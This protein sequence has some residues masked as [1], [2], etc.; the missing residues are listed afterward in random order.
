L[1]TLSRT[2]TL[3]LTNTSHPCPITIS[4]PFTHPAHFTDFLAKWPQPF[5]PRPIIR[6][7]PHFAPTSQISPIHLDQTHSLGPSRLSPLGPQRIFNSSEAHTLQP[8]IVFSPLKIDPA[9]SLIPSSLGPAHPLPSESHTTFRPHFQI[10]PTYA[11]II[12]TPASFSLPPPP[13][14]AV[15]PP[16]PYSPWKSTRHSPRLSYFHPYAKPT[17]LTITPTTISNP[18]LSSSPIV[19][20]SSPPKRKWIEID[21]IPLAVLKKHRGQHLF[22]RLMSNLDWLPFLLPH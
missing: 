8:S 19:L 9:H 12:L 6:P 5:P 2:P 15:S 14:E 4:P 16:A 1:S 7:S 13:L 22:P 20:P 18:T 11:P 21:D 17:S 3:S 10:H